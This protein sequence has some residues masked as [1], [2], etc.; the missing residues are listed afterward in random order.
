MQIIEKNDSSPGER[1][2]DNSDRSS[3]RHIQ[4]F[5]VKRTLPN[6][7]SVLNF[8]FVEMGRDFG[9][10]NLEREMPANAFRDERIGNTY[11]RVMQVAVS[12]TVLSSCVGLV[13]TFFVSII[14]FLKGNFDEIIRSGACILIGSLGLVLSRYLGRAFRLPREDHIAMIESENSPR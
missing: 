4:I 12:C 13:P 14:R 11:N 8:N 9:V 7:L 5:E 2:P 10:I 3:R 1:V 6:P